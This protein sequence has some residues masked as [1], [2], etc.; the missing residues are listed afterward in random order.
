MIQM[1]KI[2]VEKLAKAHWDKLKQCLHGRLARHG[3]A[4]PGHRHLCHGGWPG[5]A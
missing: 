5:Q 4:C 3:R 2:D 1:S